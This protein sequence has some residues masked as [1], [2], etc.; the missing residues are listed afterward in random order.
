M[1]HQTETGGAAAVTLAHY[2]IYDYAP[3]KRRALEAWEA[4]LLQIVGER[5]PAAPALPRRPPGLAFQGFV[6]PPLQRAAND[7]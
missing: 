2:A 5:S 3:E 6:D 4:L 7:A 1:A